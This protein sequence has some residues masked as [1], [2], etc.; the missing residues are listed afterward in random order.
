MKR[1][2]KIIKGVVKGEKYTKRLE[3]NLNA[4]QAYVNALPAQDRKH[5][6]PWLDDT[7]EV[8]REITALIKA[9]ERH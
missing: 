1:L 8:I 3:T 7:K 6:Q 9:V 5:L 4:I 2:F